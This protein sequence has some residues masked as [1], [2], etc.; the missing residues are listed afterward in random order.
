VSR[1]KDV[2]APAHGR[3]EINSVGKLSESTVHAV[4]LVR[5]GHEV[6]RIM[7]ST[8]P[9][10]QIGLKVTCAATEVK[11]PVLVCHLVDRVAVYMLFLV[12]VDPHNLVAVVLTVPRAGP[13]ELTVTGLDVNF[14]PLIGAKPLR[15][16]RNVHQLVLAG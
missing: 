14:G 4:S 16:L 9:S 1:L 11:G 8:G 3:A 15:I 2:I 5:S 10:H 13:D 7:T 6:V 12:K